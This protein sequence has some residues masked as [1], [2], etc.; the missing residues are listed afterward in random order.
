MHNLHD[1]SCDPLLLL[2]EFFESA[3]FVYFHMYILVPGNIVS[4]SVTLLNTDIRVYRST[5]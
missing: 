4:H 5:K 2:I 1:M 3:P